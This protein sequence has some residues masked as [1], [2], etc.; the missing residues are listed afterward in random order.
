MLSFPR[1][2]CIYPLK[3]FAIIL[4][5]I[6]FKIKKVFFI[7]KIGLLGFLSHMGQFSIQSTL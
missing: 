7:I 3:M 4:V 5:K 6:L 1:D 2:A